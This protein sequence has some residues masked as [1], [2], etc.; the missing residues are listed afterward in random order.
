MNTVLYVVG[1][2][3]IAGPA[4]AREEGANASSLG[5]ADAVRSSAVGTTALYFNPAA[6]SQFMQYAV[7]TG[8]QFVS[9]LDGH[10]FTASV[11]DSA[12]NQGLAAGFSYSYITGHEFDTDLDRTGHMVRG[13]LATG[14]RGRNIALHAGIGLRYLDLSIGEDTT[15]SGLTLDAGALMV[16]GD[17][18]RVG[19][20]GDNLIA[21]DLT[22][23]PRRLGI[24]TSLLYH[25]LLVSFDAVLDFE[26]LTDE[27]G[28]AV[29]EAQYNTGLEF[30][31][32]GQVPLR[33]GYQ[34]DKIVERQSITGGIGYVSRVVAVDFGFSQNLDNKDDNIFSL[35]VRVF[36]P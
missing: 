30:A 22:E 26:T 23:T 32:G 18:F 10:V 34:Y 3:L 20:V 15:A 25:S 19:V 24:G 13:G 21:A 33:V 27:A 7:E 28:D 2:L 12:T 17:M 29:T 1:T 5:V 14:W 8:Y 36:V 9:P 4:S 6:M 16:L 35:N 31:V 11:V